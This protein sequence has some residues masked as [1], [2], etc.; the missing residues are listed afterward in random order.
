MQPKIRTKISK[1]SNLFWYITSPHK[2]IVG[3]S[4][5]SR[6][7]NRTLFASATSQVRCAFSVWKSPVNL[8]TEK[9][10]FPSPKDLFPKANENAYT[11]LNDLTP[12]LMKS[13]QGSKYISF[14]F[15]SLASSSENRTEFLNF[16][17]LDKNAL[18]KQDCKRTQ[19]SAQHTCNSL[20]QMEISIISLMLLKLYTYI[21][22]TQLNSI[23]LICRHNQSL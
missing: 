23:E 22:I 18:I 11:T 9:T 13:F 3:K 21:Y 8:E 10:L 4:I 17:L 15:L 20:N 12:S 19:F 1:S 14:L 6:V 5:L 2:M 16:P 7:V